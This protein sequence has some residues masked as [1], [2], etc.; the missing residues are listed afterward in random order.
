MKRALLFLLLLPLPAI[1]R[2]QDEATIEAL[3]P[4]LMAEDARQWSPEVFRR[5]LEN[6]EP[7]VRRTAAMAVGRLRDHRGTALLLEHQTDPD[8][9]VQTSIMFAFGL[10]QDSSATG[11]IIARFSGQ[12]QLARDAALEAITALA[13]I[14]GP[15]VAGFFSGILR[16][17]Q[18][19]TTDSTVP[20]ALQVAQELWRLGGEAPVTDLLPY[21]RDS[22]VM[23]RA[24]IYSLARL[25]PKSAADPLVLGIRDADA[26]IRAWSVRALTRGFA[27]SANL[28][29]DAMS[30]QL[31]RLL[32][33]DDPGVRTNTLRTLGS[34]REPELARYVAPLLNDPDLNVRVQAAATLGVLGGPDA[35]QSLNL[36][37]HS[38]D[39][40]ALRREALLGLATADSGAFIAAVPA[41]EQSPDWEERMVAAQAWASVAPGPHPGKAAIRSE[42][43]GRVIAAMLQVWNDAGSPPPELLAAARELL[44]HPD[45][46]VR[47]V[48]ADVLA[49][50]KDPGDILALAAAYRRA[51]R[52]SFPEA[53]LSALAALDSIA[54]SGSRA[55]EQVN[56]D[57]LGTTPRPSLYL[58]R[59]WA[60]SAWPDAA[61]RWGPA[62]PIETG[63]TLQDYRELARRYIVAP[64]SIRYPHVFLVTGQRT[65]VELELFGPEAPLTVANFLAL[66]DRHFFDDNIWH[67]VVP[68]FVVQDGDK[69][70]DGWGGPGGPPIRDEINRR[71]YGTAVLG[72]ALSGPDTGGSQW[73]ITLSPQPHLDGT[74]TVFGRVVGGNNALA[75]VT[76]GDRIM[77]IRR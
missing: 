55:A 6:P 48:A 18:P 46:A 10:L 54:G 22:L 16:R 61:E 19:L 26:L 7:L 35:V 56:S 59:S 32:G 33:D 14:R 51:E 66:V 73:F 42:R 2:A 67:R 44:T 52:D 17:T 23:R 75:R 27:D 69:R 30:G 34:Y 71:R 21:T 8:S 38:R 65:S 3:A 24:A 36:A 41:W 31:R 64:D 39:V 63:R 45:A 53:A 13:K 68:N 12:P 60:E 74:Y 77:S 29:A 50:A 11:P 62:Y 20:L 49:K 40:F 70:G 28:G 9:S 76:Q 25:H 4:I 15:G 58:V 72:M 57:F 37:V 43:D 5:G 1:A 47:S